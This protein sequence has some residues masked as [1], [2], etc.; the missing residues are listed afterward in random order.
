MKNH[1]WQHPDGNKAITGEEFPQQH[2]VAEYM[3][4]LYVNNSRVQQKD[5]IDDSHCHSVTIT[6]EFNPQSNHVAHTFGQDPRAIPSGKDPPTTTYTVYSITTPASNSTGTLTDSP[7]TVTTTPT[8]IPRPTPRDPGLSQLDLTV[9]PDPKA[10]FAEQHNK[11][12][13][14]EFQIKQCLIDSGSHIS[15][16]NNQ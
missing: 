13:T 8:V 14:A 4:R 12:T 10:V 3:N 9:S 2:E 15:L 11:P 6:P 16:I 5:D 7:V 1:I